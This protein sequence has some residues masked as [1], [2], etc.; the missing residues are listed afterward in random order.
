[1]TRRYRWEV[2]E[3]IAAHGIV[4]IVR[5]D[6]AVD[7][8]RV[9]D[10]LIAAGV[11]VLEV[12]L[13][14]RGALG[15]IERLCERHPDALIGAGTVLDAASARAAILAG[16]RFVMSPAL[17]A[18][19]ITMAHRYGAVA[20]PGCQT[21]TEIEAALAMGADLVK[22][23]PAAQLGPGYLSAVRAAL[24]QAPVV[25]TGGV[26]ASNAGEWLRGGAVAL[27][28]GGALT[29]DPSSATERAS[30]L[31]REV[32]MTRGASET[33]ISGPA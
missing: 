18:E 5:Q 9:S 32:A 17:S 28:V 23:F 27:G 26:D 11:G 29:S 25:P 15:V 8:E 16:A 14:T 3:G 20:S 22:L 21:P 12:S 7:A 31:L 19:V 6:R 10:A 13:T 4:A 30:E 33:T 1:M 24:P 2:A